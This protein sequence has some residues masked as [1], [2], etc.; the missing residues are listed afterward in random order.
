[1]RM[2]TRN[3]ILTVIVGA[4]AGAIIITSVGFSY[5]GW[6]LTGDAHKEAKEYAEKAVTD[7]QVSFCVTVAMDDSEF[8]QQMAKL[9]K[10]DDTYGQRDVIEGSG[11]ANMPGGPEP[12]NN[13]LAGCAQELLAAS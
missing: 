9:A 2:P 7:L 3:K 6:M 1:M 11:W 10:E 5:M 4:V 8:D 12:S 13:V